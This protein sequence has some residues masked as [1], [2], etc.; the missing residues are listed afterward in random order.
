[1]QNFSKIKDKRNL[2]IREKNG[3]GSYDKRGK[4][5]NSHNVSGQKHGKLSRVSFVAWF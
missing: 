2:V 3:D 4:P 5:E 1:M